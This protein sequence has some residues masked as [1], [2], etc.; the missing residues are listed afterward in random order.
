M[1]D[2]S[3]VEEWLAELVQRL[4]SSFDARLLLVVHVGSWARNDANEQS[5]ID[6]NVILDKV[7]PEDISRYRAIISGMPDKQL[8]CG[9]LG[10]LNEIKLWPKYD[11]TAFYYGCKVLHGNVSDMIPPIS[12]RDVFDHAM[13]M[14]ANMNHVVRHTMIYGDNTAETANA[15]KG[16]YKAAFFVIQ[17]WY[18]LMHG[19]YIGKRQELA[20]KAVSDEDKLVLE[21][22]ER[23]DENEVLRE[24]KP[25]ERLA[26]FERWSS[27]MFHRMADIQ[28]Q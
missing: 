16:L 23:W 21:T 26:L 17:D 1:R 27:G 6:V 18:L 11:L 10:G 19:E 20:G 13:T 8:A 7:M 3:Q 2:K 4:K 22:Y 15:M 25:T 24:E 9:F 28:I 12:H 14:L 5:D